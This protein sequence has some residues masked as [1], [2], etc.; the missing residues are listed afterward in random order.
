MAV[1]FV[2]LILKTG[3]VVPGLVRL[4]TVPRSFPLSPKSRFCSLIFPLE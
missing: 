2:M 3:L 4:G 1:S